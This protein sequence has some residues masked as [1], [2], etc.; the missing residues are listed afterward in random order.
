[1]PG[2]KGTAFPHCAA[3]KPRDSDASKVG[4]F[5]KPSQGLARGE[6]DDVPVGI[7]HHGEV[8]DDTADIDGRLDQ[9]VPL[10]CQLGDAIYFSARV[11]LKSEMI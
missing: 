7:A 4:H 2:R 1:M 8:A 6:F 3:A 5:L 10:L 9:D 11:A